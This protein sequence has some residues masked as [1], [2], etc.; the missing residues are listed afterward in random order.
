MF[1]IYEITMDLY[2]LEELV[3]LNQLTYIFLITLLQFGIVV[4]LFVGA[5][6][7]QHVFLLPWLCF[8]AP[9]FF[10]ATAYASLYVS[11]GDGVQSVINFVF[12]GE[13][14]HLCFFD[15][16]LLAGFFWCSWYTVFKNYLTL[17]NSI[18]YAPFKCYKYS[19]NLTELNNECGESL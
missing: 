17:K 14:K 8:T 7:G 11:T 13:S 2:L 3:E 18:K 16:N 12:I 6:K 4:S 1:R 10:M 9:T 19:A 5:C 15:S